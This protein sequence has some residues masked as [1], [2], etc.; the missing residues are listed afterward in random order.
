MDTPASRPNDSADDPVLNNLVEELAA[1]VQAGSAADIEAYLQAH[2]AHAEQLRQLLPEML[3][4]ADLGRTPAATAVSAGTE[5]E[6]LGD[7]QLVREVGRGGM[8]VV[9]EAVQRSLG[10]R[11]ALKVLPFAATLD[12]RQLQ[13]FRNEA[14]AAAGLHHTNIV[15]VYAVSCERGVHYYAMQF[16]DGE[17]LAG[18]IAQLRQ[19][20]GAQV[21]SGDASPLSE[22][23]DALVAGHWGA[24]DAAGSDEPTGPYTPPV[25]AP[26]DAT[27]P[28][29]AAATAR[30]IKSPAYFR[31]VARL[32]V[33]AAEA[34]EHAHQLGVVHRDIKP[35]NLLLDGRGNLWITDFGLAQ[36]QSDTRLT[37]T[38]DL[39]GTLRYMSPEQ[40]G[41]GRVAV[42]GRSDVYALGA[43]LYELLTLQPA[44]AQEDKQE[45]LRQIASEEPSSPR[46]LNRAIP[47]ELEI[48][49][50]K[51]LEKNPNERYATAQE[52]ADDLRRFLADEPLKARR[53]TLVQ[54]LRKWARR[55][56]PLV[57]ATVVVAFVALLA[58]AVLLW[59][60]NDRIEADKLRAEQEEKRLAAEKARVVEAMRDVFR[61]LDKGYLEV[62]EQLPSRDL[63]RRRED[64]AHLQTGLKFYE[65][66]AR[67]NDDIPTVRLETAKAFMRAGQIQHT[68]GRLEEAAAA[69]RQALDRITRLADLDRM[70]EPLILL[71]CLNNL[72]A[73]L[74]VM[75]QFAD[76]EKAFGRAV[77]IA[78]QLAKDHPDQPNFRALIATAL[79]NLGAILED[80]GRAQAAEET[81]GQARDLCAE[82][83]KTTGEARYRHQLT[84]CLNHLGS[85]LLRANHLAK[86]E[87]TYR[88]GLAHCQKLAA[89][90]STSYRQQKAELHVNLARLL[91]HSG[92]FD[93][94]DEEYRLGVELYEKLAKTYPNVPE[95]LFALADAQHG[96]GTVLSSRGRNQ[97][98]EKVLGD[99]LEL[100]EKAVTTAPDLLEFQH[101]L[102][103]CYVHWGILLGRSDRRDK[104]AT[105]FQQGLK[106]WEELAGRFP[107]LPKFQSGWGDGLY[108][109]GVLC[110]EQGK[111]AEGCKLFQEAV[112]HHRAALKRSPRSPRFRRALADDYFNLA[113]G[114]QRQRKWDE[115]DKVY[116]LQMLPLLDELAREFPAVAEYSLQRAE[117]CTHLATLRFV[118]AQHEE[119]KKLLDQALDLL[120]NL[121]ASIHTTRKYRYILACCHDGRAILHSD[122]RPRE[123]EQAFRQALEL[124]QGLGTDYPT[125]PQYQ[126]RWG[127]TLH[128]LSRQLRAPGEAAE[129]QQLFEQGIAH[130]RAAVKLDSENPTYQQ[131]LRDQYSNLAAALVQQG[132]D[133]A[134]VQVSRQFVAEQEKLAARFADVPHFQWELARARYNLAFTLVKTKQYAEAEK[135]YHKALPPLQELVGK[136]PDNPDYQNSLAAVC[137]GLGVELSSR[138]ELAEARRLLLKAIDQA[139]IARKHRPQSLLY[140]QQLRAGYF[141]LAET[142]VRL[143]DH[144]EA[145]RAL[146][147]YAKLF[148]ESVE[149]QVQT[150]KCFVHCASWVERYAKLS[151]AQRQDIVRRYTDE[152]LAL[153]PDGASPVKLPDAPAS[154]AELASVGNDL[155]RILRASGRPDEAAKTYRKAL[156]IQEGLVKGQPD[157]ADYQSA[158]GGTL[159][160]LALCL[161]DR[162]ELAEARALLERAVMHQQHAW[163]AKPQQARYARFLCDHYWALADTLVRQGVHAEAATVAAKP[164][165]VFPDRWEDHYRGA[166]VLARCVALAEKDALPAEKRTALARAYGERGVELLRQAIENGFSNA[167]SLREDPQLEPLRG[168]ADFKQLLSELEDKAK[169]LCNP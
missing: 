145:A 33:Q 78:R 92:R 111:L 4:L 22:M 58:A 127:L 40:A 73:V 80:T 37:R 13:R 167:R 72:G 96:R 62:I 14:Q 3:A 87:E 166:V 131:A 30:S 159:N 60:E 57:A 150:A 64:L 70:G 114:L 21:S 90:P 35:A 8:G 108:N 59:R 102:A 99:A 154:R 44:F 133:D 156:V 5:P 113:E 49:V 93:D 18:V 153:L 137:I 155:G 47:A 85:G 91:G 12:E 79:T 9:Y 55:H 97:E 157:N 104:A 51:A 146:L 117:I 107:T 24:A 48:I 69:Y 112:E 115:A 143:P 149:E 168:R 144:D 66:F 23:V 160:N 16:I 164:P 1:R 71:G 15:P 28:V 100:C 98:A 161:R 82:L 77:T 101:K 116:R 141:T 32:G 136:N 52:L 142:L 46:R 134:A 6:A 129:A 53:P 119:A 147:K 11:V 2:P 128:N 45:L 169:K 75:G 106:L 140:R 94:A 25:C 10:R 148:P 20:A 135:L 54:R 86:A 84:N 132:D 158:L 118:D 81:H 34:L 88:Q 165:S 31:A 61:A 151:P 27:P 89:L 126:L 120:K 83:V 41:G 26:P 103:I 122:A 138:G 68:L 63:Q 123:A 17:N 50:L 124:W 36:V 42:D 105:A 139:E 110:L 109:W 163:R 19:L 39:V 121:P 152:A 162:G 56:R 74:R 76:A 29:A 67:K 38:G 43:T 65:E 125:N 7:F 95:Y 130:T